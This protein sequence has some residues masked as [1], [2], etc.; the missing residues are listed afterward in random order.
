MSL[1]E[2]L[3]VPDKKVCLH[4]GVLTPQYLKPTEAD[5]VNLRLTLSH[6]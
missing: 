3:S 1:L 5:L 2:T 6:N 4:G